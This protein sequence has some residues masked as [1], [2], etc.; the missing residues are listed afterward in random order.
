VKLLGGLAL[1]IVKRFF[2]SHDYGTDSSNLI[3][4]NVHLCH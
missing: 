4:F 2:I 1:T 3:S